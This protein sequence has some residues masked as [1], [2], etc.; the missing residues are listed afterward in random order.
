VPSG[1]KPLIGIYHSASYATFEAEAGL[2]KYSGDEIIY[3]ACIN[4][5]NASA[6]ADVDGTE[7]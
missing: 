6:Y 4:E 3:S 7:H 1:L 5:E 2:K